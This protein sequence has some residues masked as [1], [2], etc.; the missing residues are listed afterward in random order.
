MLAATPKKLRRKIVWSRLKNVFRRRQV[1]AEFFQEL[2][3]A[4]LEADVGPVLAV[5]WVVAVRP[6]KTIAD[7]QRVLRERMISALQPH[8]NYESPVMQH[9]L[10]ILLIVGV[11]GAG[12]TTTIAKLAH[13]ALTQN[14]RPLLVAADTFRAAAI[15]QLQVWGDRL[16]IPVIAQK[17][18][19]DPAAVAFDGVKAAQA[20]AADVVFIDTAGRLHTKAPLMEELAKVKRVIGKALPGAP[21]E[22]WCVLDAMIG[23]NALA[24]V[25]QFHDGLGLTG[26]IVTKL[27]GTARAGVLFQITQQFPLPIRYCGMGERVEDLQPFNADT[28]IDSILSSALAD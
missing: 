23:Q 20:R 7:V 15:E 17:S 6:W 24:Q 4:L 10:Q 21:H 2:E 8:A 27:D 22:C 25:R 16:G 3:G 28:F 11:N 13:H 5:A 14:Q 18:G 1:D 12:K 9:A 19:A 26:L